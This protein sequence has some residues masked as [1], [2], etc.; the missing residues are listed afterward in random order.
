MHPV[1]G[2]H[3]TCLNGTNNAKRDGNDVESLVMAGL[4]D[5]NRECIRRVHLRYYVHHPG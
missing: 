4:V 1:R 3:I 2:M 5:G